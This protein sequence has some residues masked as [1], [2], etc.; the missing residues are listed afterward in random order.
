M[1]CCCSSGRDQEPKIDNS[2]LLGGPEIH[3]PMHAGKT[4]HKSS[5]PATSVDS[6]DRNYRPPEARSESSID[7]ARKS[8]TGGVV[9]RGWLK[10]R[11]HMVHNW[12]T[13]YFVLD[14]THLSYYEKALEFPPFGEKLKGQVRLLGATVE[15]LWEEGSDK[16]RIHLV[17]RQGEK[18]LLMETTDE[19]SAKDW[20]RVIGDVIRT[21]NIDSIN[22]GERLPEIERWYAQ[23]A[24]YHRAGLDY[25]SK[26]H[27]FRKHGHNKTD[28]RPQVDP[29]HIATSR[30][31]TGL[32]W[33]YVTVPQ[34][35]SSAY[36]KQGH[37]HTLPFANIL[38]IVVDAE[39]IGARKDHLLSSTNAMFSIITNSHALDLEAQTAEQRDQWVSALRNVITFLA[40]PA[41]SAE[42]PSGWSD[43]AAM[44]A[45][46]KVTKQRT[47]M[48]YTA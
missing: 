8:S 28:D 7:S 18:D 26:G 10:K 47:D 9:K 36:A 24:D 16:Y 4:T 2:T 35:G 5:S 44:K 14:Q 40:I 25:L 30:D 15:L 43:K 42:I 31:L 27:V 17:G 32:V 3:S 19:D 37:P 33:Q 48:Q 22:R 46:A 45:Y 1:G 6:T 23:Q 11:G 29:C 39:T 20:N 12:K 34:P 13:R 41:P 21:C 38:D